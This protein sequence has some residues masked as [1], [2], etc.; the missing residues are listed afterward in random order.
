[1][2]TLET[3]A[4]L[5]DTLEHAAAAPAIIGHRQGDAEVWSRGELGAR[6]RALAAGLGSAGVARDEVVG[7]LAPNRPQWALAFLAIVRAGAIAMPI[8]EQVSAAELERIVSHS[9]CRRIFT[10]RAFVRTLAGLARP[11]GSAPLSLILLDDDM[12][13]ARAEGDRSTDAARVERLQNA[14]LRPSGQHGYYKLS[15]SQIIHAG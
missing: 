8:N 12:D 14:Y 3:L 9:G 11:D 7:L 5:I 2:S 1:V 6:V 13:A 4:D 10:T 15:I